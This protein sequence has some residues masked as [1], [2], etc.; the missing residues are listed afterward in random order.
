MKW[1]WIAKVKYSQVLLFYILLQ[2]WLWLHVV[3]KKEENN[4]LVL[5]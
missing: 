3:L 2:M 4:V 1:P 5:R